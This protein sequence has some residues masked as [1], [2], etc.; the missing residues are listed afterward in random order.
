MRKSVIAGNW[1][2][3]KSLKEIDI[4]VENILNSIGTPTSDVVL[5]APYVYLPRL[6]DLTKGTIIKIGAQ[7]MHY[8]DK[9]AYTGEVSGEM[10]K[11]IGVDYVIIG[12]SERRQYY[13]ETD[14][15]VNLKTKKA[16]SLGLT[17]IVCVGETESE[18]EE[19]RTEEVVKGQIL[20]GLKNISS[21]DISKLI[22]AYEPIW[23]IGTGKVATSNDAN[24]VIGFIR[25]VIKNEFGEKS[26]NEIRIQYGGSVKPDNIKE[27]LA[28]SDVDGALVGGASLNPNDFLALL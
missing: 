5:C 19:F 2:M 16:L 4:F 15:D 18:K 24:K 3:H 12:H 7:N 11:D 26:A 1:K 17:P 9:G 10:L 28:Q 23:A 21:D 13:N 6:L 27:L 25:E 20:V 8:E 22:I 14:N